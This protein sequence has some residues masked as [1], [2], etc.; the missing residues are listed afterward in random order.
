MASWAQDPHRAHLL[1][2]LHLLS[3]IYLYALYR[4]KG[5]SS[6]KLNTF[7]EQYSVLQ[8]VQQSA[9]I[10]LQSSKQVITNAIKHMGKLL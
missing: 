6:C 2:V 9:Q 7:L 5:A 4:E 10:F 3:L 8:L 1:L